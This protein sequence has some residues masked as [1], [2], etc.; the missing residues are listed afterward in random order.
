[1]HAIVRGNF[2][3]MRFFGWVFAAIAFMPTHD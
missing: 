3:Q 2:N 1:M